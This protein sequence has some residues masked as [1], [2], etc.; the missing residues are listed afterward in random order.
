MHVR[1]VRHAQSGAHQRHPRAYHVPLRV[2][3][4]QV[5][6]KPVDAGGGDDHGRVVQQ[7][8][9]MGA[10]VDD[11]DEG[12]REEDQQGHHRSGSPLSPE[13]RHRETC[14]RGDGESRQAERPVGLRDGG[15]RGPVAPHERERV[16]AR[17]EDAEHRRIPGRLG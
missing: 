7:G 11:E 13:A 14:G 4:A 6:V 17:E 12:Q 9:I 10:A 2:G 3:H 1:V 16:H 5:P 8:D 15:A